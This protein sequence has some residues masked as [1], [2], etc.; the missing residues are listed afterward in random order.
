MYLFKEQGYTLGK[1][2]KVSV[3]S[4]QTSFD[5]AGVPTVI[6]NTGDNIVYI[7]ATSGVT[8]DSFELDSGDVAFIT[9]KVFL[10]CGT[11]LTSTI[12]TIETV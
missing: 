11:D 7:S 6:K 1:Q 9:N 10:I 12:K 4:E 5:P 3:T 2:S 8:T